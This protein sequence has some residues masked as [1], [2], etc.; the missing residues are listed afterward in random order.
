MVWEGEDQSIERTTKG[1][2]MALKINI[3]QYNR[4]MFR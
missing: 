2:A 4:Y 3:L 1:Q